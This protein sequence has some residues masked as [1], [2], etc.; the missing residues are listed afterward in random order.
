MFAT[1]VECRDRR[2][3]V[4]RQ[5]VQHGARDSGKR[6]LSYD[7]LAEQA[8]TG[9]KPGLLLE[10]LRLLGLFPERGVIGFR[11]QQ[12]FAPAEIRQQQADRQAKRKEDDYRNRGDFAG[13]LDA[14]QP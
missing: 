5:E 10:L 2:I 4:L 13:G 11:K 14:L 9:L 1:Y 6:L 7:A 12:Q 3:D 8:L